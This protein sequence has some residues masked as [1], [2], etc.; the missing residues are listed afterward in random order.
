LA[1]V[2]KSKAENERPPAE[3]EQLEGICW[4]HDKALHGG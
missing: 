3:I 1:V 2:V 4:Q